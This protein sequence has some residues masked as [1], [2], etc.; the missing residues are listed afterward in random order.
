MPIQHISDKMLKIMRR[1]AGK[2]RI[3]ELLNLMRGAENSF[4]RSGFIVGHPGESES[5]FNELCEFLK[6][7]KFDRVSVFAYSKEENTPSFEMENLPR[8][9]VSKRINLVEKITMQNL[10]DTLKAQIGREILCEINGISSEGEMFFGAKNVLWDKDIDGEILINDSDV[11]HVEMGRV[12]ECKI[13][14]VSGDKLIGQIVR[15]A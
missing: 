4:L 14:D 12:Y 13:T 15:E 2:E 5:E 10:Q 3:L 1:G 7:F 11:S 6:E 9:V 8:K